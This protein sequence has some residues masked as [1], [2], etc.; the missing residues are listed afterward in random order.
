MSARWSWAVLALAWACGGGDD[1]PVVD[2]GGPDASDVMPGPEA[3]PSGAIL[4]LPMPPTLPSPPELG[5]CADGWRTVPPTR[6]DGATTCDPWPDTG[7]ATCAPDEAHFPG[8]AGCERI[9][10]ACPADGLPDGLPT[11]GSVLYVSATATAGG[12]GSRAAPFRAIA[13]AL[14]VATAGST[15]AVGVGSYDEPVALRD[16][17]SLVGACVADTR[18]AWST[19]DSA[20]ASIQV[21][22]ADVTVRDLQ[23]GG[24]RSG[25]LVDRGGR[26]TV[27]NVL[28]D[29]ATEAGVRVH[30]DGVADITDLVVR[31]TR[32]EP[33]DGLS[34]FGLVV[35]L[36]GTADVTRAAIDGNTTAGVI[37][38]ASDTVLR[39]SDAVVANTLSVPGD[40]AYGIGV[41]SQTGSRVELSRVAV[42][43][44]RSAAL[45]TTAAGT[46]LTATDSVFRGTRQVAPESDSYGALTQG[47]RIEVSRSLF[48]DNTL[49]DV[50]PQADGSIVLT[51]V[52]LRDGVP[53]SIVGASAILALEGNTVE[54]TRLSIEGYGHRGVHVDGAGATAQL[55]DVIFLDVRTSWVSSDGA[56]M[57]ME[58]ALVARATKSGGGT[59]GADATCTLRDYTFRDPRIGEGHAR[60]P[61]IAA[62][63]GASIDIERASVDGAIGYALG[64]FFDGTM[65]AADV[66]MSNTAASLGGADLGLGW[67]L[68]VNEDS[69]ANIERIFIDRATGFGV[70]VGAR[71]QVELVDARIRGTEGLPRASIVSSPWSSGLDVQ[72]GAQVTLT[73]GILESNRN[74]GTMASGEGTVLRLEDVIVRDTRADPVFRDAGRGLL[75]MRGSTIEG[76]YVRVQGNREVAVGAWEDASITLTNAEVLNTHQSEC[77]VDT[78]VDDAGGIA[79][80]AF[81]GGRLSLT[82]FLINRAA[83]AGVQVGPTGEADLLR[84]EVSRA[85]IGANVQNPD[86]DINRLTSE[87]R[88]IDNETNLGSATLPVPEPSV[89]LDAPA[90]DE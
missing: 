21:R 24:E 69:T 90:P 18:I 64:A 84:G 16:G 65:R 76:D 9:G 26:A 29:G 7:R 80:G 22:G 19:R 87:V 1:D 41:I 10:P 78:C 56:A 46:V 4:P 37:A 62:R 20:P 88:Y 72:N 15:L 48:E 17:V 35:E 75:A 43:G 59:V 73:R 39:L 47:G 89:T 63:E 51:D 67:G 49:V 13:D 42:E 44:N 34:A 33:S 54:G 14:A 3:L 81:S 50:Y 31:D 32:V 5:P 82:D 28:V 79:I 70:M 52:V 55:R 77:V 66:T 2:G 36:G 40:L 25:L 53:V 23:I 71:S 57:T 8:G 85:I 45:N 11:D 60:S 68:F 27:R 58:R 30:F 12:D 83:L 74:A 86:F 6:E 38:D 61:A